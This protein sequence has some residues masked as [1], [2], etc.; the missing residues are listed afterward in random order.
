[1]S[2]T[3]R[4][5]VHA[6]VDAPVSGALSA[7]ASWSSKTTILVASELAGTLREQGARVLGPVPDGARASIPARSRSRL[8]AARLESQGPAH[9]RSGAGDPGAG[10]SADL[11][12]G[13]RH[14]LHP[15]S[16]RAL[17]C[18]QKPIDA[19]DLVQRVRTQAVSRV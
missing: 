4:L 11:H 18:L 5:A 17:P 8:C 7:S 14:V 15:E 13:L 16:L 6:S 12:H 2:T 3:D 10:H 19:H 9:L 1:M